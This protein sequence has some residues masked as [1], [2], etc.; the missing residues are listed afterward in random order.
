M[1]DQGRVES[2][3]GVWSWGRGRET[4]SL[5]LSL[6]LS[7]SLSLSLRV[8]IFE[9]FDMN[10]LKMDLPPLKRAMALSFNKISVTVSVSH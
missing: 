1:G 6:A 9:I 5:A 8:R 3:K 4:L 2:G 7:L 10:A